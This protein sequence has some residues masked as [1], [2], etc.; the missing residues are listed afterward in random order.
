[1][2]PFKP[3]H[4]GRCKL[5]PRQQRGLTLLETLVALGVLA[6]LATL[7]LP[8]MSGMQQRQQLVAAAETL[9]GD[10]TEARFEAVRS[11]QALYVQSGNGNAMGTDWC[12]AVTTQANCAC[13]APPGAPA[14]QP[15][16]MLKQVQSADHPGISLLG[17][18]RMQVKSHGAVGAVMRTELQSRH[19][20]RLRVEVA[21]LGR[22]RICVPPGVNAI[23]VG[24]YAA[25]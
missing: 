21:A 14:S 11:G 5:H 15:A 23:P 13:N 3:G 18:V 16:C 12:W 19:G 20:D 7:A 17:P 1:M 24:R 22:S 2:S 9:A 8:A 25:C 6:I 10:L 4:C